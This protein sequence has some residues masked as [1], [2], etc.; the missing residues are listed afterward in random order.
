MNDNVVPIRG[1][2]E[3]L[4]CQLEELA[5]EARRGQIAF[6]AAAFLT[7]GGDIKYLTEGKFDAPG[8]CLM[9]IG[10]CDLLK[11]EVKTRLDDSTEA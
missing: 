8:G 11:S 6:A 7:E 1:G 2:D 4:A 3:K 10:V 9:M 5:A